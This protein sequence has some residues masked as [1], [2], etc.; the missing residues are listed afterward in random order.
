MNTENIAYLIDRRA[1]IRAAIN[2]VLEAGQSMS[3]DDGI[4][5]TRGNVSRLYDMEKNI[6][7]QLA[8]STGARPLFQSVAMR[9]AYR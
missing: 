5:Y 7:N 2:E 9:T 1:K 3:L 8:R 4:S 6:N